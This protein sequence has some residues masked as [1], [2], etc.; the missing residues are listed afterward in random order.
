MSIPFQNPSSNRESR[1]KKSIAKRSEFC[2]GSGNNYKRIGYQSVAPLP[3]FGHP[4][5]K[6]YLE[7]M[8]KS[9]NVRIKSI[10]L[11]VDGET[12]ATLQGFSRMNDILVCCSCTDNETR[13]AIS[14]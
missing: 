12:L 4:G 14:Q 9:V 10:A 1:E 5:G 11:R 2:P 3:A 13:V 8:A 6:V 7:E